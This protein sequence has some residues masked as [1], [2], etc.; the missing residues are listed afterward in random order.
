MTFRLGPAAA[1]LCVAAASASGAA[2][3]APALGL[4]VDCT[5]GET[6]HVQNHVDRDPGPGHAD[7]ACG[8][9]SYDGHEGT[10][11]AL[12]HLAAM[13][14]GVDVLAAAPGTVRAV[15]DAWPDVSMRD[16]DAPD[17]GGQDCGN[18]VVV[19]HG[20]GWVTQYCH[21][22]RGSVAVRS[23]DEVA[24][25]DVLGRIGLSGRTEFPHLHLT[26]RLRGET[27]DPFDRG[28]G[29]DCAAGDALWSD[30]AGL[31]A[32]RAT[33]PIA[34]G[35]APRLPTYEEVRDMPPEA[36]SWPAADGEAL[37]AW[38]HGFGA[39]SGDV[40][41]FEIEGPGGVVHRDEEPVGRD[42]ASIYRGSGRRA[43][44]GGWP[45]GDYAARIEIV[46]GGEVVAEAAPRARLTAR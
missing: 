32:Y 1:A 5:L 6:C 38:I 23:G 13:R 43:P 36:S 11:F 30:A 25:G 16:P 26:L 31:G 17:L 19:D 2:A 7:Y 28:D 14:A 37:V 8:Q 15:R 34:A 24:A 4:P 27:V 46:R 20:E 10:D 12:P 35:L 44:E 40:V 42:L 29:A 22:M 39:R 45:A 33:G 3:Q 9:L 18:G 21:L 41:R